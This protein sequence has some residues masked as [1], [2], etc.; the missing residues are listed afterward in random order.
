MGIPTAIR[1]LPGSA[2]FV[3][4]ASPIRWLAHPRVVAAIRAL[5]VV[6]FLATIYAGLAGT[7]DPYENLI[8]TMVRV[9]WWVGFAFACAATGVAARWAAAEPV[10]AAE[11]MPARITVAPNVVIILAVLATADIPK[12]TMTKLPI[13]THQLRNA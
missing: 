7:D 10:Q 13:H 9:I 3:W 12:F 4:L 11:S 5:S 8:T 6:A 1:L 2:V